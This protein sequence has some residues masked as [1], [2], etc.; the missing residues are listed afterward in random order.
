MVE[1]THVQ[2]IETLRFAHNTVEQF[3]LVQGMRCELATG[4]LQYFFDLGAQLVRNIRANSKVEDTSLASVGEYNLQRRSGWE[5]S[6]HVGRCDRCRVDG[7]ESN[8]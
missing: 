5:G 3:H 4:C 6:L 7:T 1:L 2:R 8:C